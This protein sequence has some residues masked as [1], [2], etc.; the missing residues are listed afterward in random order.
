MAEFFLR[1]AEDPCGSNFSVNQSRKLTEWTFA[2]TNGATI[3]HLEMHQAPWLWAEGENLRATDGTLNGTLSLKFQCFDAF[4]DVNVNRLSA[5]QIDGYAL[6]INSW[7][8][9]STPNAKNVKNNNIEKTFYLPLGEEI[10]IQLVGGYESWRFARSSN[11]DVIKLNKNFSIA[12]AK[13]KPQLKNANNTSEMINR[14]IISVDHRLG[15]SP[16]I[17]TLTANKLGSSSITFQDQANGI[18]YLNIEVLP[19]LCTKSISIDA[20]I[21]G[22][23][24]TKDR[25]N[26]NVLPIGN[27]SD[28]NVEHSSPC[29]CDTSNEPDHRGTVGITV[30]DKD[31]IPMG[32]EVKRNIYDNEKFI[33]GTR[34]IDIDNIHKLNEDDLPIKPAY[35][36][37]LYVGEDGYIN[38]PESLGDEYEVSII[39]KEQ[40]NINVFGAG[41]GANNTGPIWAAKNSESSIVSVLGK[42]IT[43]KA[44]TNNLPVLLHFKTKNPSSSIVRPL[45]ARHKKIELTSDHSNA[46]LTYTQHNGDQ[47][48]IKAVYVNED[49]KIHMTNSDFFIAVRC[50]CENI[51]LQIEE[52]GKSSGSIEHQEFTISA[53]GNILDNARQFY[54]DRDSVKG[55]GSQGGSNIIANPN[56]DGIS[57]EVGKTM[58]FQIAT[59]DKGK[60]IVYQEIVSFFTHTSN[61]SDPSNIHKP[62]FEAFNDQIFEDGAFWMD[63][64]ENSKGEFKHNPSSFEYFPCWQKQGNTVQPRGTWCIHNQKFKLAATKPKL[65]VV[66]ESGEVF[67]LKD[68]DSESF[69]VLTEEEK[70]KTTSYEIED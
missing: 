10:K 17:Y 47:S 12:D 1:L 60:S 53:N 62:A 54:F 25:G 45:P 9:T 39:E 55:L 6:G 63:L 66:S 65:P 23:P 58:K 32:A 14:G 34:S 68:S 24:F 42:K 2:G 50:F 35:I 11:S 28:F 19:N 22:N 20:D 64:D 3:T 27:D 56:T 8:Y 38:I 18:Y 29:H 33:M 40:E 30:P 52:S 51:D 5:I 41:W 21:F 36:Y 48:S 67:T 16:H 26:Y 15:S 59:A 13:N 61:D 70:T 43:C 7:N 44:P 46:L 31:A 4:K 49:E 37:D 69:I 57:N